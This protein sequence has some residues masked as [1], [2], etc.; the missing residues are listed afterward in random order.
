MLAVSGE[1]DKV[2]PTG[3]PL[4]KLEGPTQQI[5]RFGGLGNLNENAKRSVYLPILRDL[6]PEAL[7]HFDFPDASL[8]S[9]HRDDTSVPSQALYLMNNTSV[10]KL[11]EKGAE[12]LIAK[13]LSPTERT[14]A[15]FK[16]AFG[17]GAS[18]TETKAAEQFLAKMQKS[19]TRTG[20][21]KAAWSA[22]LQAL[23]GTAEFRYLD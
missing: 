7:D 2:A 18:K 10:M 3:S 15:A 5:G 21:E 16:L 14:E 8:V 1:L 12:K 9:G 4:Q 23:Y 6:A 20:G 22:L 17:R 19:G 11:A 13:Y